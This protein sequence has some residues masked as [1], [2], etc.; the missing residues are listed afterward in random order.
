[1]SNGPLFN[2]VLFEAYAKAANRD[3]CVMNL[4][5]VD[6]GKKMAEGIERNFIL[7][8]GA[9]ASIKT[10]VRFYDLSSKL[11]YQ[12]TTVSSKGKTAVKTYTGSALMN[13]LDYTLQSRDYL[14]VSIICLDKAA[15]QNFIAMQKAQNALMIYYASIQSSA[16][17][18]I[19]PE[20]QIK[21]ET[22]I[23]ALNKYRQKQYD[24][25]YS[26]VK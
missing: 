10:P 6:A 7:Y 24:E 17:S 11:H 13:G 3:V 22:Y 20:L 5:C 1:M 21:K 4:D 18:G 15:T 12:V 26:L 8:N 25:S 23:E 16:Q 9:A 14:R 19:T 2:F